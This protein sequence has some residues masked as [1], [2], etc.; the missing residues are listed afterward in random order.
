MAM[1]ERQCD[2]YRQLPLR[3]DQRKH[4]F[5]G[6]LVRPA[7]TEQSHID[8]LNFALHWILLR[9]LGQA[10]GQMQ[11]L[12]ADSVAAVGEVGGIEW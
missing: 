11:V 7:A 8:L 2:H 3:S 12:I 1:L 9:F 10:K 4:H 5:L 6:H